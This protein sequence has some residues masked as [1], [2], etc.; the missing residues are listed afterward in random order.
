MDLIS[1]LAGIALIATLSTLVLAVLSYG[2]L[3]AREERAVVTAPPPP[4]VPKVFLVRLGL[5]ETPSRRSS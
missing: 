3:R 5:P 1:I 4:P 2:V